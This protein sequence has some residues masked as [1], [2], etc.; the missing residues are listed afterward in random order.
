MSDL[1]RYYDVTQSYQIH[2]DLGGLET[3]ENTQNRLLGEKTISYP[4]QE[5]PTNPQ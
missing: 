3:S 2:H 5:M 4:G 1:T